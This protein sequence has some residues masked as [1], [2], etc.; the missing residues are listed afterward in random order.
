MKFDNKRSPTLAG[1][2]EG[3]QGGKKKD[4]KGQ[5]VRERVCVNEKSEEQGAVVYVGRAHRQRAV[6]LLAFFLFPYSLTG[7]DMCF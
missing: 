3:K 7:S 2:S 1:G 5:E 4:R 6:R